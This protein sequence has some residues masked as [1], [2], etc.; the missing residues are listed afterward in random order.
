MKERKEVK[1]KSLKKGMTYE[2]FRNPKKK[3]EGVVQNEEEKQ[4]L[5]IQL[6]EQIWIFFEM[7]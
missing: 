6:I 3:N 7:K 2:P 5:L 4:I 1:V